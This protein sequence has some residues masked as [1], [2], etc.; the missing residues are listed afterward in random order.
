[1]GSKDDVNDLKVHPFF[2][3]LSWDKL[4]KKE[5]EV[6]YKPKV[7]GGPGSDPI[8]FDTTFTAE[9]VVDSVVTP[10]TLSQTMTD[11]VDSFGEFTYNPKTG[12]LKG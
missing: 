10:G 11:Q 2:K 8:N 3:P 9:P 6:P 5:V 4:M 7:K 1:M 12:H